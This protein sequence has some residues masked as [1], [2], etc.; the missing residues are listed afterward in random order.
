M[1][2]RDAKLK[3]G[4]HFIYKKQE[5]IFKGPGEAPAHFLGSPVTQP[6]QVYGF[7]YDSEVYLTRLDLVH[8]LSLKAAVK[9]EKAGMHRSKRPSARTIAIHELQLSI[10]AGYDEI[11]AALANRVEEGSEPHP[12]PDAREPD[13]AGSV[14]H[15]EDNH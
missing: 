6:N 9:L 15:W 14:R 10:R 13:Y 2:I 1:K 7:L 4:D 12:E 8:L 3:V 5:W 11:I